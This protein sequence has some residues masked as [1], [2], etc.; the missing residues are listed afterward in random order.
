METSATTQSATTTSKQTR[1]PKPMNGVDTPTLFATIGA[2]KGQPELASFQFRATNRWQQ[3]THSRTRIEGFHGA[4]GE[5]EHARE[6]T[7]DADHPAVLVG[8]DQGPTPIE[9]LLHA[10][11]ACL[12]AGIGN[13][14]SARG[15]TLYEV[16]STV[17]GD[18]DLRG[19]LGLSGEVRNGYRQLRVSFRIKG[20]APAE[21]L[22]EIVAQSRARSA[23]Y[24]VLTNGVPVEISVNA[25]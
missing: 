22:E 7:Y 25:S 15:V 20:D 11:A 21:K 19:I 18:I 8:R 1:T 14:A 2:V 24:D 12:T 16:E 13:I 10:I 4:G 23:V 17:V 3:G 9:F 5:H 6:F